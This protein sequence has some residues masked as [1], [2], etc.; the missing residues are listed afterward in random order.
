MRRGLGKVRSLLNTYEDLDS[1]L[2]QWRKPSLAA[3]ICKLEL[4]KINPEAC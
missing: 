4:E 3:H 2:Q 1:D